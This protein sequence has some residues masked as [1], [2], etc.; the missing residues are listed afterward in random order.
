MESERLKIHK[1]TQRRKQG[2]RNKLKGTWKLNKTLMGA[3]CLT[4]YT[5]VQMWGPTDLSVTVV[6]KQVSLHCSQNV[7]LR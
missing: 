5:D 7:C 4:E 2:K 6:G 1:H 3:P